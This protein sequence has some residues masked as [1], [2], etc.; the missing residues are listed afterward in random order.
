MGQALSRKA[1]HARPQL[2]ARQEISDYAHARR[3]RHPSGSRVHDSWATPKG[4]YRSAPTVPQPRTTNVAR[5]SSSRLNPVKEVGG[6]T[7]TPR[8]QQKYGRGTA[9]KNPSGRKGYQRTNENDGR[10]SVDRLSDPSSQKTRN[11]HSKSSSRHTKPAPYKECIVC[12]DTRPLH[13]FPTRPPTEE[14][15]HDTDVCRRCVRTWIQSEF[16]SK[17]WNEINCT[18]CAARLQYD[19]VMAFAPRDVF[20]R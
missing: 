8:R 17:I 13:R 7:S 11:Q 6:N 19:D 1:E 12:T 2:H 10:H 16:K 18:I 9:I 15:M 4:N 3:M 5:R 20:R 14:C